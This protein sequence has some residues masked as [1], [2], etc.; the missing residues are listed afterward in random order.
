MKL[1]LDVVGGVVVSVCVL[2]VCG[3]C[4]VLG[5]CRLSVCWLVL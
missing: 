3:M 2:N 4:S 5:M 1:W